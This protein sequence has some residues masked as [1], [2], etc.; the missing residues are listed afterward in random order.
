[1]NK[2]PSE[3][4][5]FLDE[6]R[7]RLGDVPEDRDLLLAVP[8][9]HLVP[10]AAAAGGTRVRLAGQDLSAHQSGAYTGEVSG[11]ML[12]DAGATFVLVGHSE[13]REYHAEGDE[14]LAAKVA[15]ALENDLI[16]ILCVG[17]REE[18][19]DAGRAREVVLNQLR[20]AT[21][22]LR[23]ASPDHLVVAYEP[24]WAI[25]TG[26]TATAADAQEMSAASRNQL[27]ELFPEHASQMRIL[28]GGSMKPGNAAE[29]LGQPDIDGGLIGGASLDPDD[30]LAI[31]TA[32]VSQ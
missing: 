32:G 7:P 30:F 15:A 27:G 3:S 11:A 12:R 9:T 8:A 17:E 24:V 28:Y 31:A 22:G 25:G 5:R 2:L 20:R 4:G 6:L 26:R 23:L 13:R 29:L 19:R 1:M 18:E 21:E 10:M 14:L 16:P